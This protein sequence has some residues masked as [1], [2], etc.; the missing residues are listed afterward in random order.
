MACRYL[1]AQGYKILYRNFK[2]PH[3]GEVDIVARR[4]EMLVF[5]EVKTRRSLAY[6]RPSAAVTRK[7]QRLLTRGAFAWL[8]MLRDPEVACRFDVVEVVLNR[9]GEAECTL[10][11]DAFELPPPYLY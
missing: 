1:R 3:G 4:C 9:R 6:G 10:I 8:R 2:A 5:V 7:K 11:E